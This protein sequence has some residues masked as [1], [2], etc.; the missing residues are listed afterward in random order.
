MPL[1]GA[2]PKRE[3]APIS[4]VRARLAEAR[5]PV[6]PEQV[7]ASLQRRPEADVAEVLRALTALGRARHVGNGRFAP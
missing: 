6:S 2:K 5:A 1:A 4:A 7:A 3:P